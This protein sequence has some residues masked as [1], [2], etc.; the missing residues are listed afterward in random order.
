VAGLTNA[1]G[2]CVLPVHGR[3]TARRRQL[4]GDGVGATPITAALNVAISAGP[5]YAAS[6]LLQPAVPKAGD[7]KYNLRQNVPSRVR[8]YGR[9]KKGGDYV[10]LEEAG[11]IAYHIIVW[12]SHRIHSFEQHWLHDEAA[13]IDG[14]GIVTVP[15]DFAGRVSIASRLGLSPETHYLDV[16]AAFPAIWKTAHRGDGLASVKMAVQSVSEQDFQTVFPRDAVAYGDREGRAH[17]GSAQRFDGLFENLPSSGSTISC[18][19][20][21]AAD[22]RRD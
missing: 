19:N 5:S 4:R 22:R 7:G 14:S 10:F 20:R 11:G 12:A 13:T 9:V 1:A 18:T 3:C 6:R 15:A 2:A 8:V 21:P 16:V 17:L